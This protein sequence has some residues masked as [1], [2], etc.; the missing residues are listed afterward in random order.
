MQWKSRNVGGHAIEYIC[1]IRPERSQNGNVFL[2]GPWIIPN[3]SF[4][5]GGLPEPLSVSFPK[6]PQR[7]NLLRTQ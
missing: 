6:E 3:L 5:Q 2:A 1:E 7:N 4:A